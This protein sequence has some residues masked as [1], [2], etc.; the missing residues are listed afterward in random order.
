MWNWA[1]SPMEREAGDAEQTAERNVWHYGRRKAIADWWR[2]FT[3]CTLVLVGQSNGEVP[4]GRPK[5]ADGVNN[6][7]DNED[8]NWVNF[9]RE[10]WN[11]EL[12]CVRN[13]EP[14]EKYSRSRW[15]CGLRRRSAAAWLLGS[16]VRIP[17]SAWTF[18]LYCMLRVVYAAASTTGWSLVHS[19]TR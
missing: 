10:W 6:V 17:L 18:R 11:F 9:V 5:S 16:R 19:T 1:N 7:T 4:L 12:T 8:M 3:T 2:Y 14:I 13:C 15:P